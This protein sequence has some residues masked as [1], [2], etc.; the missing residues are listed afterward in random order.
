MCRFLSTSVWKVLSGAVPLQVPLVGHVVARH[1]SH[2]LP[3]G[4]GGDDAAPVAET[5][6]F[7]KKGW[8]INISDMMWSVNGSGVE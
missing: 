1:D 2:L 3:P 4:R 7:A 8:T 6:V 5:Q